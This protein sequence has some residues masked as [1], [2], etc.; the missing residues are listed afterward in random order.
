MQI[1]LNSVAAF[2]YTLT[3]DQGTDDVH[4]L[5]SPAFGRDQHTRIEDQ[6]AGR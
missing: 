6:S 1:A 4:E 2:H 3:D 5:S